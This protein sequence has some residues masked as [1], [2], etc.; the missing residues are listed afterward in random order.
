MR[1]VN[2]SLY[3]EEWPVLFAEESG[4]I[5]RILGEELVEIHHFGSTSVP[6]L[7]AK[8]II[9]MLGVVKDIELVDR[10]NAELQIFGYEGKGENGIPG[11]RYFQKGGDERTHHL[12]IYQIGSPE[13]GRHLVFRDFLRAHPDAAEEYGELKLRLAKQ[14]PYDIDSY[15]NGKE[16]LATDI[17]GQAIA[18]QRNQEKY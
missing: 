13:I 2:V 3:S 7:A 5:K 8:S 9:D 16:G 10:F 1:R 14:F 15:I 4:Q 11:R 6:S 18:W 12:H 17:Q